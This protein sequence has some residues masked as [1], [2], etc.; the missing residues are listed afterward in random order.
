MSGKLLDSFALNKPADW[1]AD[2]VV[3]NLF[4]QYFISNYTSFDFLEDT[5]ARPS[6]LAFCPMPSCLSGFRL[7]C[8]CF[9]V[10]LHDS[11]AL[12][13]WVRM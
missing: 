7:R 3:R 9:C 6:I 2:Y 12:L 5:G 13:T 11:Q 4:E 10:C 8:C 1:E